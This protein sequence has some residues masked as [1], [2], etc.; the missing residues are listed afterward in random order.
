MANRLTGKRVAI[1]TANFF[2]QVEL[3]KPMAALKEAGAEVKIVSPDSGQI[4]GMN[5]AEKG[6]KMEVDLTLEEADP[7]DFD[8][9]MIPGGTM[10]PDT[11]REISETVVFSP[12]S[13]S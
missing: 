2:E 11:L 13:S 8:A 10:N 1:L 6:D 9:L 4:Q 12:P 7:D 5:H 3:T